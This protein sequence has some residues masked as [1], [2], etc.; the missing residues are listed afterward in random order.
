M[1]RQSHTLVQQPRALQPPPQLN[2][3]HHQVNPKG[4]VFSRSFEYDTRRPA[5]S[6]SYVETFSRS[7]DGNL[8]ERPTPMP[9]L[10]VQRERSLNFSTL[11]GNSPNYLTKR[12]A[13]GGGG[14]GGGLPVSVTVAAGGSNRSLR[15]RDNSPKYLQPQTTAYLNASVKEA[16]PAYSVASSN[17]SKYSPRSRHDR[18]FERSKSHNV[19]GRS[20]KSQFSR[21]GSS[22]S[23]AAAPPPVALGMSRFRSLDTTINN[24]LN[25][26][27][28][29]ARSGEFR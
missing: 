8:S 2:A 14:G 26:C 5:P 25:S 3:Q 9:T 7:F 12:E 21:M 19:I 18:S 17:L 29:G 22:N 10:A 20:R 11:T 15:S 28:S 27:D 4:M 6:N 23:G 24:R 16:P 1:T 13:G